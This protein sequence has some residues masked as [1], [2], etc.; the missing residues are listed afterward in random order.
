MQMAKDLKIEVTAEGVETEDQ[1]E[2]LKSINC[3]TIQGYYFAISNCMYSIGTPE[4]SNIFLYSS[5]N[6]GFSRCLLEI[7]TEMVMCLQYGKKKEI[8]ERILKI[9]EEIQHCFMPKSMEYI[10]HPVFG[11]YYMEQ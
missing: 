9:T 7:L 8:E 1:Y 11:V 2:F 6:S 3:D 10:L 4:S 5:I